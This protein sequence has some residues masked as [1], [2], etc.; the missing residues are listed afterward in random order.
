MP[1]DVRVKGKL[2]RDRIDDK[3]GDDV[4][5]K[6][7]IP[8]TVVVKPAI[9]VSLCKQMMILKNKIHLSSLSYN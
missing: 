8:L 3:D 1:I 9:K 4:G 6:L 5:S 7:P 2:G